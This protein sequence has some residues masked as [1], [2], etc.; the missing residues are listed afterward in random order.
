MAI[1][2]EFL[3]PTTMVSYAVTYIV[4]V[5]LHVDKLKRLFKKYNEQAARNLRVH[6]TVF[7]HICFVGE[8]E[9]RVLEAY[10]R[11]KARLL[12]DSCKY[13]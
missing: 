12:P 11:N 2:T 5:C 1:D 3:L 9:G 13:W 6:E 7:L 8:G 10:W 4:E